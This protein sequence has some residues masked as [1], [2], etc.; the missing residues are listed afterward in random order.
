MPTGT[1]RGQRDLRRINSVGWIEFLH[2]MKTTGMPIRKCCA[3]LP[4]EKAAV[5]TEAERRGAAGTAACAC[6]HSSWELQ[7]CLLVLDR[8][9]RRILRVKRG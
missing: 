6:T 4:F 7:D 3:T 8:Q 5:E 2:R 9:D 1:N